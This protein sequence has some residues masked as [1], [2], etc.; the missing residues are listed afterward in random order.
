[1]KKIII[2]NRAGIQTH[3]AEM[4]DPSVWIAD[5]IAMN[6]WGRPERWQPEKNGDSAPGI[7]D[8]DL[9]DVIDSE[10][11]PDAD[12]SL[13]H[14]VKLK[15]DYEI[16]I[17]DITYEHDLDECI[18]NRIAEYPRPEDFMN[19]FFDGGQEALDELHAL[20]L[21]IKAKYP[22]PVKE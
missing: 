10:D 14:W 18:K 9:A 7:P 15:A 16:E 5:C 6:V 1:M 19:A 11:R 22:K 3:G 2:K 17:I 20:R 13:I 8:Y 21:T 12:G 4:E